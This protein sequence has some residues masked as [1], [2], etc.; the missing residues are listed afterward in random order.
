[1]TIA[2][3]L[4]IWMDHAHAFPTEYSTN[5]VKIPHIESQFTHG[6]KTNALNKSEHLMHNQE[7]HEQSTYYKKV[8]EVM[9]N[10]DE[11]LLFG[12]T[13]AKTE[14]LNVLR[15]DH[16]FEKIIIEVQQTDKMSAH[17]QQT[18]INEYFSNKE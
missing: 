3:K 1:M 2:K 7:K 12:P 11:V 18:F 15:A 4:G 16:R 5:P 6:D 10:Y 9:R 17:D 8:G 13:D 14:L